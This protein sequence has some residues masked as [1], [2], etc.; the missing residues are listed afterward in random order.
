[1]SGFG[2]RTR[3]SLD[4]GALQEL[5]AAETEGPAACRL[6]LSLIPAE[7]SAEVARLLDLTEAVAEATE[8]Q[9]ADTGALDDPLPLLRRAALGSRLTG[10]EL[11]RIARWARLGTVWRQLTANHARLAAALSAFGWFWPDTQ[12]VHTLLDPLL[13]ED[14]TLTD[15]ASPAL[16]TLR[17]EARAA[18][19]S[20]RQRAE[21]LARRYAESMGE[22]HVL[23]RRDRWVLPIRADRRG[24]VPGMV[25]DRSASGRT[26]HIEPPALFEANEARADAEAR[27]MAEEARVLD[28]LVRTVGRYIPALEQ[29]VR[30]LIRMDLAQAKARLGWRWDGHRPLPGERPELHD[31][32]HPLLWARLGEDAVPVDL[33]LDGQ[34]LLITGPNTGGKT[35]AL[36]TLGSVVMLTQA[37]I[38]PPVAAGSRL[39]HVTALHADIGDP[40]TLAGDLSTFSGHVS[41]MAH[42]LPSLSPGQLVLLDEV[43]SGTD[44]EEGAALARA[45]LE[46]ILAC[47]AWIVATTHLGPL[48][49]LPFEDPRMGLATTRF[50]VEAMKP[51]YRLSPGQPGASL[52]L[53]VAERLGMPQQILQRA[54]AL[55][56]ASRTTADRLLEE[57]NQARAEAEDHGRALALARREAEKMREE[58]ETRLAG[59]RQE[60]RNL[61]REARANLEAEIEEARDEIRQAIARLKGRPTGP[62][63]QRAREQLETAGRERLQ[64]ARPLPA[65]APLASGRQVWVPRLDKWGIVTR[66]PD[67]RGTLRV[68]VGGLQLTLR[69]HEVSEGPEA[70]IRPPRTPSPTKPARSPISGAIQAWTPPHISSRLDLRGLQAEEA[71]AQLE[72]WLAAAWLAG[73]GEGTVIHGHG[74]GALLR[75]V[76]RHLPGQPGVQAFRPGGQGEGGDGVTLVTFL[77]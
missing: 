26:L 31:A 2:E 67:E 28:D 4:W 8:G 23:I 45:I 19:Q 12:A 14:G 66:P 51:Y 69:T 64:P 13:T 48:K 53:A 47:G 6:A 54:R 49:T 16:G 63:V 74:T 62:E 77:P 61:R 76:R 43:G 73:H 72:R 58:L 59:W 56:E 10:Q 7:D 32:R 25:L 70:G 68:D 55:H 46:D 35:A 38:L 18:A 5:V 33:V 29:T 3:A 37:G 50:D 17:L 39:P 41:H 34:G 15:E 36:K 44:P 27:V 57:L 52:G 20:A 60:E 21:S 42:L 11:R 1:M 24:D 65:P 75:A 71:L 30:L 40:Q 9:R 22:D